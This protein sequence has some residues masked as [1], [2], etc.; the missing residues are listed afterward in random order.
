MPHILFTSPHR[1]RSAHTAL[2][3]GLQNNWVLNPLTPTL[4]PQ[5]RGSPQYVGQ[6]HSQIKMAGTNPAISQSTAAEAQST[7]LMPRVF[8]IFVI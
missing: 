6:R 5:G 7:A 3:R 8:P 4:N 1:E 2:R